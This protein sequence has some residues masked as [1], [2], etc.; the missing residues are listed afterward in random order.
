MAPLPLSRINSAVTPQA[1]SAE[2]TKATEDSQ[3]RERLE[4]ELEASHEES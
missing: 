1:A 4:K 3:E 2:E